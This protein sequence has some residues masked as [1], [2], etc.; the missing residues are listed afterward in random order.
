MKSCPNFSR[1]GGLAALLMSLLVNADNHAQ[2][3]E[4][5]KPH[6]ACTA[7][8]PSPNLAAFSPD[9]EYFAVATPDGRIKFGSTKEGARRRTE[10]LCDPR[11]LV[12]SP[13]GRFLAGTGGGR[14]CPAKIK[15]WRVGEGELLCKLA[16]DAGTDPQM[17][18]SPDG[19]FLVST[20]TGSRINL[21]QLD[22]GK[23]KWS[24]TIPH[25]VS[26]LAFSNEGRD[27][28]AILTDGSLLRFAVR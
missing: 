28:V 3:V 9:G 26:C 15:V 4:T 19:R 11:A 5:P 27:V 13:D 17:S 12:F 24:E 7:A 2:D 16:T 6:A 10:H 18:F 22:D 20:G 21:W 14:N 23:L 8:M 25:A 1:F